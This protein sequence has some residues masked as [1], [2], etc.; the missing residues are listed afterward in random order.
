MPL[1]WKYST[2]TYRVLGVDVTFEII[3]IRC[4]VCIV[5]YTFPIAS[6]SSLLTTLQPPLPLPLILLL[7]I[8]FFK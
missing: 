8:F 4:T 6:N 2:L 5:I 1:I 7:E 3:F